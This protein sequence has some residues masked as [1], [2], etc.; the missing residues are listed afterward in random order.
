MG[1]EVEIDAEKVAIED[2]E[3]TDR[4]PI[5]EIVI[6]LGIHIRKTL[7]IKQMAYN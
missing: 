4:L 5:I 7:L 6:M 1:S 2:E 3:L